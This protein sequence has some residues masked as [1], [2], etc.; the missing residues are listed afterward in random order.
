ML[1]Y[2]REASLQGAFDRV[3]GVASH[4]NEEL[5]AHENRMAR[6][7]FAEHFRNFRYSNFIGKGECFTPCPEITA[8]S[9]NYKLHIS[10]ER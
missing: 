7:K 3:G 8:P 2:S 9:L 1:K 6:Q 4:I 10:M 5:R